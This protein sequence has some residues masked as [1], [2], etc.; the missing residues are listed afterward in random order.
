MALPPIQPIDTGAMTPQE[1][2]AAEYIGRTYMTIQSLDVHMQSVVKILDKIKLNTAAIAASCKSITK[3]IAKLAD[4]NLA[5]KTKADSIAAAALSAIGIKL[6]KDAALNAERML[7]EKDALVDEA[8]RRERRELA[9]NVERDDSRKEPSENFLAALMRGAISTLSILLAV[10]FTSLDK[11]LSDFVSKLELLAPKS[12]SSSFLETIRKTLG[13][14][15]KFL[16]PLVLGALAFGGLRRGK[17]SPDAARKILKEKSPHSTSAKQ[18]RAAPRS[19]RILRERMDRDVLAKKKIAAR[20][21]LKGGVDIAA[22]AGKSSGLLGG[23]S[24]LFKK[25]FAPLEGIYTK[26]L[27]FLRV[28]RWV[29]M[30]YDFILGAMIGYGD[31]DKPGN[32]VTAL[33]EGLLNVM[34]GFTEFIV[35]LSAMVADA[36]G[37]HEFSAWLKKKGPGMTNALLEMGRSM[38]NDVFTNMVLFMNVIKWFMRKVLELSALTLSYIPTREYRSKSKELYALAASPDFN[39]TS[40]RDISKLLGAGSRVAAGD[41]EPAEQEGADPAGAHK[42]SRGWHLN[43]DGKDLKMLAQQAYETTYSEA[44]KKGMTA[45]RASE[46]AYRVYAKMILPPGN[47]GGQT[48]VNVGGATNNNTAVNSGGGGDGGS[49][50]AIGTGLSSLMRST[51]LGTILFSFGGSR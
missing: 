43:K 1:L 27:G 23:I 11:K 37:F 49:S 28:L 26:S 24:G 4:H 20:K 46:V 39:P 33:R 12:K 44:L 30:L 9:E 3:S 18:R 47:N 8:H 10:L 22:G 14:R 38:F 32:I 35:D 13:G 5:A 48:I 21:A 7:L 19:E 36:L 25:M 15:L 2:L 51:A 42:D 50:S 40:L 16:K 29:V 45:E 17:L 31:K 41:P 34:K 6:E